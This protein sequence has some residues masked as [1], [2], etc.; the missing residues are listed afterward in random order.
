MSEEW[1]LPAMRRPSLRPASP[2]AVREAWSDFG[3]TELLLRI[4]LAHIRVETEHDPLILDGATGLMV[5][6]FGCGYGTLDGIADASERDTHRQDCEWLNAKRL[7][8]WGQQE[9]ERMR[10]VKIRVGMLH[11]YTPEE[12]ATRRRAIRPD[13]Q[14]HHGWVLPN[15]EE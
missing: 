11:E 6:R 1:P 4:C 15:P 9:E 8:R 10:Q 5:C 7:W 12:Q 13:A 2:E 14:P 3:Y